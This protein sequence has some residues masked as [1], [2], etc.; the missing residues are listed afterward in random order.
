[1]K[2]R[3]SWRRAALQL[4]GSATDLLVVDLKANDLLLLTVVLGFELV[5]LA[6]KLFDQSLELFDLGLIL[7]S[8]CQLGGFCTLLVD[9]IFGGLR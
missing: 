2:W 6:L 1:M 5:L 7:L 9:V 4:G 3:F 8:L